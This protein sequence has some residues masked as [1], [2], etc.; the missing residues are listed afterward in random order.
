MVK[1][2]T[3]NGSDVV[4]GDRRQ[5]KTQRS[6]PLK[7]WS[8]IMIVPQVTHLKVSNLLNR[9]KIRILAG[10]GVLI[11]SKVSGQ[12]FCSLGIPRYGT[13]TDVR[14]HKNNIQI[15]CTVKTPCE[16]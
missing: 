6:D 8:Y 2:R 3:N 13:L 15:L 12:T 4:L 7:T 16:Q 1:N 14:K 11:F 10:H 5:F 9:C